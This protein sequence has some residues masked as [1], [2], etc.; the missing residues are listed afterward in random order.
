MEDTKAEVTCEK[1]ESVFW[2]KASQYESAMENEQPILC[3]ACFDLLLEEERK[4]NKPIRRK[5]EYLVLNLEDA[6]FAIYGKEGW[7]LVSV[8]NGIVYFKRELLEG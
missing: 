5:L 1:C 4:A 8:D 7:E 6:L 3:N 2:I